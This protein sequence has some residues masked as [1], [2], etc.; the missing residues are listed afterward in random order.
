MQSPVS[1]PRAQADGGLGYMR[2]N[3]NV[4]VDET[5]WPHNRIT[6][7][8]LVRFR[9]GWHAAQIDYLAMLHTLG[10]LTTPV[11][12]SGYSLAEYWAQVRYLHAVDFAQPWLLLTNTYAELDAH[13][14]TILS[15]DFGMGLSICWLEATLGLDLGQFCDGA[16][17]IKNMAG[18]FGARVAPK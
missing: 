16:Y 12:S 5:T 7:P 18:R 2:F 11:P 13:Q 17:F 14:K 1:L 6:E 8:R 15:D 3:I 10:I 9:R 4:H